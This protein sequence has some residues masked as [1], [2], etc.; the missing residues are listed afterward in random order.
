MNTARL[1][2]AF[3][4]LH[5]TLSLALFYLSLR[6][7]L[8]GLRSSGGAEAAHEIVIG[9]LEALGA[10][11]L[12]IPR[13]L[14]IGAVLVLLTIGVAILLHAVTGTIRAD[15]FVYAAATWFVWVHGS[16]WSRPAV[17]SL[18]GGHSRSRAPRE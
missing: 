18:E 6:T 8:H 15:L 10:L 2:W 13:T 5:L 17:E 4:A 12:L 16:A 7:V 1:R 9:G 14:G 11:L 3:V